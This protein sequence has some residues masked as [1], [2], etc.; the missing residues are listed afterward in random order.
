MPELDFKEFQP[1][2]FIIG[3]LSLIV[4]ALLKKASKSHLKQSGL[5]AEGIVFA[6]EGNGDNVKDKV[7]VRFVTEDKEWI[8]GDIN[9]EF[10]SFFTGQYKKGQSVDVYYDPKNPSHFFVDTKQSE[11]ISR[12]VFAVVGL[13]FS[14]IGLYQLL[15]R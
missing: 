12:V 13:G 3:G 2:L 15:I 5:K 7:T 1:Y 4:I 6:L 14:L 8:T 11:T 9:Q 10:A